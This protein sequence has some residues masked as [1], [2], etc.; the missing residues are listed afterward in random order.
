MFSNRIGLGLAAGV[1][2]I[3]VGGALGSVAPPREEEASDVAATVGLS[4]GHLTTWVRKRTGKTVQ[5]W[6]IER[7]IVEARKLLAESDLP[8]ASVAR[9][10]GFT[11][12]AYFTRLFS[13]H[14]GMS[15]SRWRAGLPSVLGG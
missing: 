15:P 5:A 11:D 13:R 8:V 1:V 10:V 3:A 4:P 12:P 9:A 7:K 6:I 2:A 14:V